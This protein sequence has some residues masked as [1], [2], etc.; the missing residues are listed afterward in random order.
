MPRKHPT[1]K[2]ILIIRTSAL[3]DVCRSVPVLASLRRA[4]PEARIDW[5]VRAAYAPAVEHHKGLTGVVRLEKPAGGKRVGR[6]PG[7]LTKLREARYDFV[8]DCQ[9]LARSGFWAWATRSPRRV[10]YGFPDARELSW[11]WYTERHRSPWTLH[12]VD[13]ML[14]LVRKSGVEPVADMRLYS[15]WKEREWIKADPRLADGDYAVIAPTSAWPGKAWPAERWAELAGRMVGE[16]VVGRV[17]VVGSGSERG[18]IGPVLGLAGR[19]PRAIDL[20][21]QTDVGQ[22]MALI[23]RSRLVVANDS[24]ALHMAVGFDRPIVGLFGPTEIGQVGPYKRDADVIQ[25]VVPRDK[26]VYKQEGP[27]RALMERIT[28]EEVLAAVRERLAAARAGG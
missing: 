6:P 12:A 13:R 22:L 25:R 2:S 19:E 28:V 20:V 3:G 4:Y 8:L 7:L 1:P 9:G 5:L 14:E 26:M 27:G 23:E 17:V 15:G 11:I 10:G 21:G 24:A 16:G 18:Q